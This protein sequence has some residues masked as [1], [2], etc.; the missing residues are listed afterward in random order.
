MLITIGSAW[1]YLGPTW[2]GYNMRRNHKVDAGTIFFG[3]V[4]SL[5]I[6]EIYKM[7]SDTYEKFF[8]KTMKEKF[9][10]E[11]RVEERRLWNARNVRREL[12]QLEG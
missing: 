3:V 9:R 8:K 12:G 6:T 1:R 2:V 10:K 5:I 4:I 7:L 11:G